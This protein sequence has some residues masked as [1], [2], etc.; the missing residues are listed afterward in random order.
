[1]LNHALTVPGDPVCRA[2]T[3]VRVD[4]NPAISVEITHRDF[5]AVKLGG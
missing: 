1:M 3:P 5:V 2:I 4:V